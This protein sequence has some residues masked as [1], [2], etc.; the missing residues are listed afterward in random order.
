MSDRFTRGDLVINQANGRLAQVIDPSF[1]P[2]MSTIQYAKPGLRAA[3][4]R[5]LYWSNR[6]THVP[7]ENL[8]LVHQEP[9]PEAQ[10]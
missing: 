3:N 8:A 7:T 5:S 9:Q 10:P 2:G 4:R 6:W 1:A